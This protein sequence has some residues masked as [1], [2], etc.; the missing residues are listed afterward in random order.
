MTTIQ[1]RPCEQNMQNKHTPSLG[2]SLCLITVLIA[3]QFLLTGCASNHTFQSYTRHH[4]NIRKA[5]V[6]GDTSTALC[7]AEERI[8]TTDK[9]LYLEESGRI[10]HL[11]DNIDLSKTYYEDAAVQ[12]DNEWSRP[13]IELFETVGAVT[14]NDNCIPYRAPA[15]EAIFVHTYQALNYLECKD[16]EGAAVEARRAATQQDQ[17]Y[18][19]HFKEIQAAETCAENQQFKLNQES[20]FNKWHDSMA[21]VSSTLQSSFQNALTFYISGIIWELSSDFDNAFIAYQKAHEIYP[22]NHYIVQNMIRIGQ[23]VGRHDVVEQLQRQYPDLSSTQPAPNEGRL[24]VIYEDG[25]VPQKRQLTIPFLIP[26]YCCQNGCTVFSGYS[27]QT[28]ALPYY[29]CK[30][31][32]CFAPLNVGSQSTIWGKTETICN[33][34]DMAIKALEEQMTPIL[35]RQMARAVTKYVTQNTMSNIDPVLGLATQ[36]YN[37]VSEQ[38]DLRSWLTLP[39]VVQIADFI[40]PEGNY[41]LT[42]GSSNS[43][44]SAEVHTGRITIVRVVRM[45]ASYYV[46]VTNG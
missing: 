9:T 19:R 26:N 13:A 1:L 43:R 30:C 38:A 34:R 45:D 18:D 28:I 7:I 14:V 46:K 39:E 3:L 37:F 44:E 35:V 33:V 5:L 21:K 6:C 31:V 36:I 32:S 17:A 41:P 12:I 24:V 10:A 16:V 25:F 40:L 29:D 42:L 4:Q 8:D 2:L 23:K 27:L 22:S 20:S 11:A 15:Y